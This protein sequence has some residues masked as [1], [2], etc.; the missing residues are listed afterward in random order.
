[1]RSLDH[2]S[3]LLIGH[4]LKPKWY[5]VCVEVEGILQPLVHGGVFH[6]VIVCSKG[7]QDQLPL[8]ELRYQLWNDGQRILLGKSDASL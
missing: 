5:G 8:V 4:A 3:L 2:L 6:L 1:V 7:C